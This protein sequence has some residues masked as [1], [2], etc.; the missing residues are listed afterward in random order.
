MS[1]TALEGASRGAT[2][3]RVPPESLILIEDP[4]HPRYDRRVEKPLTDAFIRSLM[5]FGVRKPI[6]ARKDGK[7]ANGLDRLE[8]AD[9]RRRARGAIEANRRLLASG[10]EPLLVQVLLVKGDDADMDLAMVLGNEGR[11]EDDLLTKAEKAQRLIDRVGEEK[12]ALAFSVEVETMKGW[13]SL[14]DLSDDIKAKVRV[15]EISSTAARHL[16]DIPREEQATFVESIVA[17]P[18]ADAS[19]PVSD[20]EKPFA[21]P[22]APTE[23]AIKDAVK[24]RKSP[25]KHAVLERLVKAKE[26]LLEVACRYELGEAKLDELKDAASV[27]GGTKRLAAKRAAKAK[28]AAK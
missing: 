8:V 26:A 15:G 27:Y 24:R 1:K 18:V 3:F 23:K 17:S 28:K 19:L 22:L 13:L 25:E 16:V 10:Q 9:G 7:D 5:T 21:A 14:L 20:A 11:L 12:A 4:K 6:E 2:L